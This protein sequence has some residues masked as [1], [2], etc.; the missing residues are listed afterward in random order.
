SLAKGGGYF[1]ASQ[2]FPTTL[3]AEQIVIVDMNHD[4]KLD[5]VMAEGGFQAFVGVVKFGN[6]DGSFGPDL[7][8]QQ[9]YWSQSVAVADFDGDYNLDIAFGASKLGSTERTK[10]VYFRRGDGHG[11]FGPEESRLI[12]DGDDPTFISVADFNR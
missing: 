5:L 11:S 12:S 2:T 6:G 7:Q 1:Y 9:S 3:P 8:L 10:S 4:G